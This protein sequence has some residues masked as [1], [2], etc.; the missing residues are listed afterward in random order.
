MTRIFK[1]VGAKLTPALRWAVRQPLVWRVAIW[2]A[3]A[4]VRW[5]LWQV[6]KW[7]L[8]PLPLE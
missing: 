1:L 7:L 2:V 3:L 5:L 4:A 6:I 8:F